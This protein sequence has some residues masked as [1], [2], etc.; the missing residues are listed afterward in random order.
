MQ[1]LCER[2]LA[3]LVRT[4]LF[5]VGGIEKRTEEIAFI[6]CMDTGR[7]LRFMSKAASR[8]A[9]SF[10]FFVDKAPD[11]R[12]GKTLRAPGQ[13]DSTARVPVGSV[14]VITPWNLMRALARSVL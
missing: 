5:P 3:V 6:E 1:S 8:G 11:V 4:T 9:E 10:R 7:A 12:D 2:L 14:A 13:V